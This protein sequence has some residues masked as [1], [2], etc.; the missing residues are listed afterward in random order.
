MIFGLIPRATVRDL[1]PDNAWPSAVFWQALH[2]T[3]HMQEA[4][5][6]AKLD[7]HTIRRMEEIY[8]EQ[9]LEFATEAGT[10]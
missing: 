2:L 4:M 6:G 7:D 1:C 8:M 10:A 9:V 3:V 5:S